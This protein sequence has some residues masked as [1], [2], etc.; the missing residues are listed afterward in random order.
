MARIFT[1]QEASS[2]LPL[3]RRVVADILPLGREL[4]RL[5]Q[6]ED[7]SVDD[8]D[9][10]AVLETQ[11][12]ELYDELERIGCSFRAPDFSYGLVDFPGII[13]GKLV[14]LCWK[15]D[16]PAL[17]YYHDPGAGFAGRTLIPAELL[18]RVQQAHEA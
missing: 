9:R 18:A 11:L 5:Q 7:P 2:A 6:R 1:P 8:Q 13:D 15:D 10:Q 3:V 14:Y 4:R 16:E 12:D 17:R